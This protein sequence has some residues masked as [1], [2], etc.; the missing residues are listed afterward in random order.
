MANTQINITKNGTTTLA[1]SGKYCDRNIDV[2]VNLPV[3]D[4]KIFPNT[5]TISSI[6]TVGGAIPRGVVTT[7]VYIADD[8]DSG[9]TVDAD[10]YKTSDVFLEYGYEENNEG[11]IVP[12]LYKTDI[13]GYPDEI[14]YQDK[15]FYE[16]T[17]EYDGV[18]YDKW[19]KIEPNNED[20]DSE[21]KRW[22]LT[23]R[24]V[25]AVAR[26]EL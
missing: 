3:Y 6:G 1:T 2:K 13:E 12:V 24:V 8:A 10:G 16:G 15:F 9:E 5:F 7:Q 19:R 25:D 23:N 22:Y 18:L 11:E 20:W 14:D 4:G 21:T 17:Y 26:I